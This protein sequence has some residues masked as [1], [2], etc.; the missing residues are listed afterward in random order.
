M[1]EKKVVGELIRE[2]VKHH[3]VAIHLSE[4]STISQNLEKAGI[5]RKALI[6]FLKR[7]AEHDR[8]IL[9]MQKDSLKK[10]AYYE[11]KRDLINVDIFILYLE[12]SI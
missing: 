2:L 1:P 12:N 7:N 11:Q 9:E 4:E 3:N 5:N 8:E 6:S 10:Q